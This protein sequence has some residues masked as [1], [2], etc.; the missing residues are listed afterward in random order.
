MYK[1]F[2]DGRCCFQEYVLGD[3]VVLELSHKNS[4]AVGFA[5]W[6]WVRGWKTARV[7][8]VWKLE[9]QPFSVDVMGTEPSLPRRLNSV[10]LLPPGTSVLLLTLG[11]C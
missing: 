11:R 4:K 1:E 8:A 3:G 5:P 6:A 9:G 7:E 2:G 10:L